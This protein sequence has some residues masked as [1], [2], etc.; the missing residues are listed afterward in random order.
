MTIRGFRILITLL[1]TGR[2]CQ[3][4]FAC[5]FVLL[6]MMASMASA[7]PQSLQVLPDQPSSIQ[8]VP[9]EKLADVIVRNCARCH[10]KG[11]PAVRAI[12]LDELISSP[13]RSVGEET[14]WR[15]VY[16]KVVVARS[17]PP[18][19]SGISLSDDDRAVDSKLD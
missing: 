4:A 15:R 12:A 1:T 19:D 8:G 3:A 13:S 5:T 11:S 18:P 14:A 16:T 9:F 17:M 7:R 2:I 6:S 10:F